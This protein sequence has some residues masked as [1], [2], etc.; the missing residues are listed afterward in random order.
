MLSGVQNTYSTFFWVTFKPWHE[1]TAKEEQYMDLLIHFNNVLGK[2]P[3]GVTVAFPP[4]A[5]PGVG[6]SGGVRYILGD[7]GGRHWECLVAQTKKLIEA[8]RKRAEVARRSTP[9]LPSLP[10]GLPEIPCAH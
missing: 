1:R 10:H 4:P 7:R 9:I 5:I 3:E 6:A 8:A 2:L